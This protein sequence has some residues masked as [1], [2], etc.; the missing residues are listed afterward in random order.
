MQPR[1]PQT[2]PSRGRSDSSVR[3]K[4]KRERRGHRGPWDRK[5]G[6]SPRRACGPH[7]PLRCRDSSLGR[8]GRCV[9]QK[10]NQPFLG[11]VSFS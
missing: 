1:L 4:T 3:S 10:L 7:A 6:P 9:L 2:C 8:E 11:R 5:R